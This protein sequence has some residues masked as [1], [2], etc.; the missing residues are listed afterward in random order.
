MEINIWAVI[1]AAAS[2]FLLG[3]IWYSPLLFLKPWNKAMNRSAEDEQP[4]P[5]RVF[6]LSFLFS[7]IAAYLFARLIGPAPDLAYAV[8]MGFFVGLG[9]VAMC[10]GINYQFADRPFSALFIDG[11]YHTGQFVIFGAVLGLWH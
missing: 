3:G 1:V 6:G 9:F 7:L 2:S 10:F 5:A 8:H 4:H 11:G